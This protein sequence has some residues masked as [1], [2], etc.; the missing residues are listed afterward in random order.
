[1]KNFIL[2][3][4]AI[5]LMTTGAFAA[6]DVTAT[7][8]NDAPVVGAIE[9]CTGS[10]CAA[11]LTADPA[12]QFTVKVTVTDPNG[13]SD[14]NTTAFLLDFYNAAD[15]QGAGADWDYVTLPA[16]TTGTRDGCTQTGDVYCLQVETS[17][18]T[19]KFLSGGADIYVLA[20][21]NA[22]ATDSN[23]LLA[24]LTVNATVGYSL[25][26]ATG[27]YSGQA[28]TTENAINTDQTKAFI[29]STHSG[30]VAIDLSVAGSDLVD[31]GETITAVNQIISSD[32]TYGNGT[33]LL[34]GGAA[35]ESSWA[36]GTDPTS[37][38]ATQYFWLDI[39]VGT[40]AGSY[41]GTLTYSS[42]ATA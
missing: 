12:T 34:I 23:E 13:A 5:M 35:I 3:V 19:T 25:D 24:A 18:W 6:V 17:D 20:A 21:D 28:D 8:G 37:A 14:I 22:A 38:T 15:A 40:I 7:V 42:S 2:C 32:S 33:G 29:T 39:P 26:A 30:N 4:F 10:T 11:T 1:M 36:R 41:T 27:S 31:G 9:I 16:V